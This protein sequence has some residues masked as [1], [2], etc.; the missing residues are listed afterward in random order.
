VNLVSAVALG[1][2]AW[3][4]FVHS[5]ELSKNHEVTMTLKIPHGPFAMAFSLLAAAACIA[6]LAVF[7][8]Y[9]RGTR[10]PMA[11]ESAP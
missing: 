7:W 1:V 6:A 8:S 4:L 11:G 9:L 10:D 3:R 2:M 5:G